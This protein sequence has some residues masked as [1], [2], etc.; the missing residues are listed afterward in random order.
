[1]SGA[2][3]RRGP[4]KPTS[5]GEGMAGPGLAPPWLA[6]IDR[7]LG[8]LFRMK[9]ELNEF[10][11]HGDAR[12]AQPPGGFGL[13]A[14][15]LLDGPGEKFALGQFNK[16]SM[17]F[18]GFVASGRAQHFVNDLPERRLRRDPRRQWFAQSG[19]NV[20]A[21][22]GKALR[23]EQGLANDIFE[24]ADVARPGLVL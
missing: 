9:P 6:G 12:D 23:G 1:M 17:H 13:V 8:V 7:S 18:A 24:F 3:P 4:G 22:D 2:Q 21:A 14:V 16:A 15:S 11:P 20:I 19:P 10:R 5:A